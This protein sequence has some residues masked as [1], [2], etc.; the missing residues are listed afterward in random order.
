MFLKLPGSS[1]FPGICRTKPNRVWTVFENSKAFLEITGQ[2]MN[3][4]FQEHPPGISG[5]SGPSP[6]NPGKLLENVEI[7]RNAHYCLFGWAV[8]S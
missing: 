5:F 8:D 7:K 2:F 6:E 1:N 4:I 3:M